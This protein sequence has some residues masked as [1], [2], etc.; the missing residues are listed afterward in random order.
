MAGAPYGDSPEI[1]GAAGASEDSERMPEP[2][3]A[4]L[5]AGDDAG[6][7]VLAAIHLAGVAS[8]RPTES[9]I[10]LWIGDDGLQFVRSG[11]VF[12]R[13]SWA[14]VRGAEIHSSR[15]LRRR[16][17]GAQ[18]LLR[19]DRGEASFEIRGMEPGE[20]RERLGPLL[21]RH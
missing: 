19:S 21:A 10:E 14:Q 8:L 16:G 17:H 5:V 3:G 4:P 12:E 9:E 18:L 11:Q 2:F 6:T 1:A 20:L 13:L 15:R 7:I